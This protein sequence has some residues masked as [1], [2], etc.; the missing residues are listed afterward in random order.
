MNIIELIVELEKLPPTLTVVMSKDGEGNGFSPL[1][2]VEGESVYYKPDNTW[3]G[4][5]TND[6]RTHN[7]LACVVLWPTN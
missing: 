6:N 2:E 7:S 1:G 3:S 4:E 5:I